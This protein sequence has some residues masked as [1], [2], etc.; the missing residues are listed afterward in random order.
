MAQSIRNM[1][2]TPNYSFLAIPFFA[3]ACWAWHL[4][5][6]SA[7]FILGAS[8]CCCCVIGFACSTKMKLPRLFI[9]PHD[10]AYCFAFLAILFFADVCWAW[11]SGASQVV[12]IS[13]IVSGSFCCVIG[14]VYA[15][16]NAKAHRSGL[17]TI[18]VDPSLFDDPPPRPDCDICFLPMPFH[19][20]HRTS[21]PCCGNE[22]CGGCFYRLYVGVDDDGPCPF[23][24]S[25]ST[26]VEKMLPRLEERVKR[27]DAR[28]MVHLA[29]YYEGGG[30]ELSVDSDRIL[31]L[32]RRAAALGNAEACYFL[33]VKYAKGI[34]VVRD[35]EKARKYFTL[36]IKK[37]HIL[38]RY[39]LGTLE[40]VSNNVD[41]AVRHWRASAAAGC[42]ASIKGLARCLRRGVISEASF[43]ESNRA[44]I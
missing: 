26:V 17:G 7:E 43:V 29:M 27:G 30:V 18:A 3:C 15:V 14:F 34:L 19:V 41:L 6:S 24:R 28:A 16:K 25:S 32:Y 44:S 1:S 33:G 36:A 5:A 39:R 2:F 21:L 12:I 4:D 11:T 38:A 22:I 9:R 23:C 13:K 20:C 10:A 37:G 40:Y 8:G 42:A 35:E 31:D